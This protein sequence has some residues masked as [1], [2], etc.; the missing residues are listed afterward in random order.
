MKREK[1]IRSAAF[2]ASMTEET[3]MRQEVIKDG[4]HVGYKDIKLRDSERPI[5]RLFFRKGVEWADA[6]QPSQ[7]ISVEEKLPEATDKFWRSE[8]VL[9][10]DE[11]GWRT[12][13]MY[14]I[15]ENKWYLS[16]GAIQGD[17]EYPFEITHW[18]PIPK[19]QEE[20]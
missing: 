5:A 12:V 2:L 1:Q 16:V 6:N 9:I 14:C 17:C 3:I 20:E 4:V 13:A 15:P 11:N 10:L 8:D 18:M 19:L 7:W